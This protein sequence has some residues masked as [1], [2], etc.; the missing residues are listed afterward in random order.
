METTLDDDELY[1]LAEQL[2]FANVPDKDEERRAR[3]RVH[4]AN[5]RKRKRERLEVLEKENAGL[6]AHNQA[7]QDEN[8]SLRAEIA[9]LQMAGRGQ[10]GIAIIA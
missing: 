3:N 7:L 4:A 5:T 10:Q 6:R 8:T 1:A 9:L 2:V